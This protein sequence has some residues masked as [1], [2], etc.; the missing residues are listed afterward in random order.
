MHKLHPDAGAAER[1]L[2]PEA[3][4]RRLARE[5]QARQAAEALLEGKS[6]ELYEANRALKETA[7]SLDNQRRYLNTI[8]D[9]TQVGIVLAQDDL[10]IRRANRSAEAMFASAG[11][12]L[13]GQTVCALF[14]DTPEA[15]VLIARLSATGGTEGDTMV[16]A[17]GRRSDGATF[18]SRWVLPAW[19]TRAVATRCGCSATSPSARRSRRGGRRWSAS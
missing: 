14:E 3:L 9:H 5:T 8:L 2:T 10:S 13:S 1:T 7:T 17:V 16:E 6:R 11:G 18:R 15:S 12:T 4:A 19:P